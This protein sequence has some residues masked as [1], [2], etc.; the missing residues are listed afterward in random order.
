M[1]IAQPDPIP[2]ELI[3]GTNYKFINGEL[4]YINP[5]SGQHIPATWIKCEYCNEIAPAVPYNRG[6][7]C[8]RE[9]A[10]ADRK[11]SKHPNWVGG[12]SVNDRGYVRVQL[13][14]GRRLQEHRYVMEQ[15][16]GRRLEDHEHV[17]HKNGNPS[18]NRPE[19][20]EIWE[21]K[22]KT[23]PNGVRKMDAIKRSIEELSPKQ[24]K[25]LLSW[26]QDL[27]LEK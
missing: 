22:P 9:C 8:K 7:Y 3:E 17:H 6:K 19:N 5:T 11:L 2:A 4:R 1:F 25:Q 12:R 27:V 20:L 24:Q 26:L 18:D 13:P 10:Y 16:L 21:V 14:D 23:H 15:V